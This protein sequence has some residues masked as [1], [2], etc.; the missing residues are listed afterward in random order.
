MK[1]LLI[2]TALG[3]SAIATAGSAT[4]ATPA[5]PAAKAAPA[6]QLPPECVEQLKKR[7][8]RMKKELNL[9][10]A[11]AAAIRAENERF[12]AQLRTARDEHHAAIDKILTPE[13]RAQAD[14][15]RGAAMEKREKRMA[16]R[17]DRC[18]AAD[19]LDDDMDDDDDDAQKGRGKPK[20]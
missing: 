16:R 10:D 6:A 13:Q 5:M 17:A 4:P 14:A 12:R 7:A 15:K 18:R 19:E 9:T 3:L 11:Q 8:D 2:A 1:H 20:K